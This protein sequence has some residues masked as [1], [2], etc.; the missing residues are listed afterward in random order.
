M[1]EEKV[2]IDTDFFIKITEKSKDGDLFVKLMNELN[3][4]PVMHEY[5]Y[6]EELC[7]YSIA[8]NLV[9]KKFIE[10]VK[11]ED[12]LADGTREWYE[13]AFR[14]AYKYFN[15]NKFQGDVYTD[16]KKGRNL[17]E[18]RTALMAV[19]MGIKVFMSD[20]CGAKEYVKERVNSRRH[21]LEVQN[22]YDV[23]MI[24]AGKEN[25]KVS[26]SEIKG[27]AKRV[28]KDRK[29]YEEIKAQWHIDKISSDITI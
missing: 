15:Y 3:V 13:N 17:G 27:C 29:R 14:E 1:T 10:I 5:V 11:Y 8:E 28:V 12:F 2:A 26:W 9:N 21:P 23:L 16:K 24:I 18:I 25:R 4:R 6:Y 22:I 19:Y 20:D 7:G